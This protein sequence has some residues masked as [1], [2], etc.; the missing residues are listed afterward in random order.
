M[1][2]AIHIRP[3]V[4]ADVP[5]ILSFIRELAEFERL[6]HEVLTDEAELRTQLF[7]ARPAAEVLIA[8]DAQSHEAAAFALFFPTFSTFVGKPGI[9]L[10][11][12]YVRPPFRGQGIG[13]ALLNR[14]AQLALERECGRFEWTVLDWNENAINFYRKMG[15]RVL[16][17]W[18]I[19]RVDGAQLQALA[20]D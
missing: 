15:A 19:C 8:E 18:R 11:D 4:E 13:S 2:A 17:D 6:S 16:D 20:D 14:L 5:L 10:E 9:H 12:L 1:H 3:A 7:G